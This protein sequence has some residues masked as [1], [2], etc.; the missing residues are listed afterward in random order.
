MNAALEARVMGLVHRPG[1]PDV[2]RIETFD[3]TRAGPTIRGSGRGPSRPGP[4]VPLR[5]ARCF[6]CGASVVRVIELRE[7]LAAIAATID[8][9]EQAQQ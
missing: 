8:A 1:C 5:V 7:R 9:K 2:A 3:A 6:D 4:A